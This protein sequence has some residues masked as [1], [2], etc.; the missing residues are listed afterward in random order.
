MNIKETHF[1]SKICG[2]KLYAKL[3]DIKDFKSGGY[4]MKRSF[5]ESMSIQEALRAL[6]ELNRK[7]NHTIIE[8]INTT[9]SDIQNQIALERHDGINPFYDESTAGDYVLQ[10]MGKA[11]DELDLSVVPSVQG[12]YGDIYIHLGDSHINN[13]TIG[14]IDFTDFSNEIIDLVVEANNETDFIN[15]YKEDILAHIGAAN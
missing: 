11:E 4:F 13:S 5:N 2:D 7:S 6:R 1:L 9:W 8:S 12:G 3:F 10:L 14:P 15:D